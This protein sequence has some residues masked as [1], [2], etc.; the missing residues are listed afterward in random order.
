MPCVGYFICRPVIAYPLRPA[1]YT[2]YPPGS[3]K[4]RRVCARRRKNYARSGLRS[5]WQKIP[6]EFYANQNDTVSGSGFWQALMRST[7][8]TG[9]S[10]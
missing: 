2:G 4:L 1:I 10:P 9:P 7:Y 5:P 6:Q 8:S 3:N